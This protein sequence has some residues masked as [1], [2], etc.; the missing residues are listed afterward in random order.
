MESTEMENFQ[1]FW[2]LK[3]LKAV[4]SFDMLNAAKD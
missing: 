1:I 2:S 4:W 3:A